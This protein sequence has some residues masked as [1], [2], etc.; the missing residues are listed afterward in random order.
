[1]KNEMEI[2]AGKG[3]NGNET[4]WG[5]EGAGKGKRGRSGEGTSPP[6]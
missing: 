6:S 5:K 1:M 4:E 2:N 3:I